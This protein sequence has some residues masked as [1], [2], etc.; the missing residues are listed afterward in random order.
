MNDYYCTN[1]L[2]GPLLGI[3]PHHSGALFWVHQVIAWLVGLHS[4][5]S[6]IA[7]GSGSVGRASVQCCTVTHA[8]RMN[9]CKPPG[10]YGEMYPTGQNKLNRCHTIASIQEVPN[11]QQF[12]EKA[13]AL[14]KIFWESCEQ[15]GRW[16]QSQ[17]KGSV[18]FGPLFQKISRYRMV[19][20]MNHE[21]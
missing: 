17:L 15:I 13:N 2:I 11:F 8:I 19:K 1:N 10:T 14:K 6:Y 16:K 18:D 4:N 9:L 21:A 20:N 5:L 3:L 7:M 12:P